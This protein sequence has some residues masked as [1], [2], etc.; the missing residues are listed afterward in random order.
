MRQN[1]HSIVRALQ[2]SE[3]VR[4]R[5]WASVS[6]GDTQASCWEWIGSIKP[7]SHPAFSVSHFTIA[8]QRVA[9]FMETGEL[10]AGGH[11]RQLCANPLC[12]RP[13]H[14][15]W[16]VGRRTECVLN[17]M[18]DGYVSLPPRAEPEDEAA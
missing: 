8:A 10:P 2:R 11:V 14:L 6:M 15:S 3:S 9:W 18:S 7:G 5:F 17:A 12:V 1:Y 4:E 13:S 16:H